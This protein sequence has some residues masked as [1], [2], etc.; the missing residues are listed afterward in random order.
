MS[1]SEPSNELR[2]LREWAKA[3]R[4]EQERLAQERRQEQQRRAR[5]QRRVARMRLTLERAINF[6]SPL[7][8]KDGAPFCRPTPRDVFP[9]SKDPYEGCRRAPPSDS[10]WQQWADMYIR[11]GRTMRI[12]GVVGRVEE[13]RTLTLPEADLVGEPAERAKAYALT[14]LQLACAGE[15]GHLAE[16]LAD[17]PFNPGFGPQAPRSVGPGSISL[18]GHSS[19]WERASRRFRLACRP[20]ESP[21]KRMKS[22]SDCGRWKLRQTGGSMLPWKPTARHKPC[23]KRSNRS[24]KNW[25]D[26]GRR[27]P[28][29]S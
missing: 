16:F 28:P 10:R 17:A 20:G 14:I 6:P 11:A 13:L 22:W 15:R 2:S 24:G 26:C 19:G 9:S 4:K 23:G 7:V 18:L 29:Q 5:Q 21:L 8:N 12:A 1:H 3:D 27:S 25:R